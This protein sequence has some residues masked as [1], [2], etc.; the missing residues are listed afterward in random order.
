M[1]QLL[2][3]QAVDWREGRRLR[4]WE[5][6]QQGWRQKDIAAALGVTNG[7]VSLW[8]KWA[9]EEGPQGLRRRKAPG[10]TPRLTQE[11]RSELPQLLERGPE[12]Y[13][14]RGAL[15]TEG[16]I[17]QVIRQSFGVSYHPSHVGRILKACGW[18]LQKPVRRAIQ[19]DEQ[20]IRRWREERWPQV[21]KRPKQSAAPSS[22]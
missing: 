4:A 17:A 10:P 22:S 18:T 12:E 13:G 19:R 1:K 11:Q 15:W 8:M 20:A 21:K 9:R 3:H 14:F 16:R 2:S 6:S 5:L 7:A